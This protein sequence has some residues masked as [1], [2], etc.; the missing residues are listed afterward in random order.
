[1]NFYNFNAELSTT[2]IENLIHIFNVYD[3]HLLNMLFEILPNT[4]QQPLS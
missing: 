2:D 3:N 1:M 4:S